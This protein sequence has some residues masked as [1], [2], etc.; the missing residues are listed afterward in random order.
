MQWGN[1]QAQEKS[2]AWVGNLSIF[3]TMP[4][5]LSALY[6]CFKKKGKTISIVSCDYEVTKK[7]ETYK[8]RPITN[9]H[10][11]VY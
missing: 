8:K 3:I 10:Y 1:L 4:I 11:Y 6:S 7:L 5:H 9:L 2:F